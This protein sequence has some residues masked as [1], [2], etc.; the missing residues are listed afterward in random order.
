VPQLHAIATIRGVKQKVPRICN[1]SIIKNRCK[2]DRDRCTVALT[3]TKLE[4]RWPVLR[5][6]CK[7]SASSTGISYHPSHVTV[8]IRA[9]DLRAARNYSFIISLYVGGRLD[10]LSDLPQ[11][12][13]L[14]WGRI[15]LRIRRYKEKSHPCRKSD[16]GFSRSQTPISPSSDTSSVLNP[17]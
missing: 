2:L 16:L 5:R 9:T 10:F 3:A 1:L 8:A 6:R 12:N 4:L 14:I 17:T 13:P 7:P 11:E 15:C